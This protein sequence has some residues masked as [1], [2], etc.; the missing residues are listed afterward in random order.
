MSE[1]FSA[2]HSEP[3]GN[4]MKE[5]AVLLLVALMLATGCSSNQTI[6]QTASGGVWQA[7]TSGGE[8]DSSG[9]SF[10]TQFTVNSNGSLS[11]SNFQLD[12]STSCFGSASA[13]ANG[14]LSLTFN[15]ADQ[16]IAPSSLSFTITS[17]AGDT[18]TFTS[19]SVTG[20]VNGTSLTGGSIIGTWT[21]SPAG[22]GTCVATSGTFTMTQTS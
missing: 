9:F 21:L 2:S 18:V 10:I 15:S 1:Q 17:S 13:S 12:N 11:I 20:T 7:S 19:T 22:G 3:E 8:G 14:T 4:L 5:V 16:L 6:A